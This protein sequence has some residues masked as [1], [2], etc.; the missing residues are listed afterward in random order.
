MSLGHDLNFT[1]YHNIRIHPNRDL[2]LPLILIVD[3]GPL[4]LQ[5][6]VL[7]LTV[8]GVRPLVLG[9]DQDD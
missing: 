3:E 1:G 6:N 4:I 9:M 2:K 8:L 5:D 7:D